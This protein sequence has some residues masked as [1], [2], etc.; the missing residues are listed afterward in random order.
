M[1]RRE[2]SW[3]LEDPTVQRMDPKIRA[4]R[5]AEHVRQWVTP[6]RMEP[7]RVLRMSPQAGWQAAF[8]EQSD[9]ILHVHTYV[10]TW[11]VH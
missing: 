2:R 10:C 1:R 4:E 7:R 9:N 6:H 11:K 3:D 8:E 5:G